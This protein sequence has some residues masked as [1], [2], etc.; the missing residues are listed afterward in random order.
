MIGS[1]YVIQIFNSPFD[2]RITSGRAQAC[3]SIHSGSIVRQ[4]HADALASSTG[5]NTYLG[6][7]AHLVET[8]HTVNHFQR[9]IL[10]IGDFLIVAL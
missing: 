3:D 7:T 6:K 10:K 4:G 2:P 1:V 5:R 8:P 9:A